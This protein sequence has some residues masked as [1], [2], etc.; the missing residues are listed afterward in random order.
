MG[1]QV[2]PFAVFLLGVIFGIFV[3]T[4]FALLWAAGDKDRSTDDEENW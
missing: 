2:S 1:V 4:V 3:T